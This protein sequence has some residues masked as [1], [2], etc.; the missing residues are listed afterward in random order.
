[1]NK[2]SFN[3]NKLEKVI[4]STEFSKM[5]QLEEKTQFDESIIDPNTKQKKP[6]FNLGPKNDWRE[7]L[8]NELRKKIE[9]EF[10]KEMLELGYLK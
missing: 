7:S 2:K 4:E 3:L 1:M 5:K 10:E 8:N 9:T 6:F